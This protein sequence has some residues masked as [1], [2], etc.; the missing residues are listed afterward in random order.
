[1]ATTAITL[2]RHAQQQ[3]RLATITAL[4]RTGT[5]KRTL[6]LLFRSTV[7]VIA[8]SF[9]VAGLILLDSPPAVPVTIS[10]WIGGAA[11]LAL[12]IVADLSAERTAR[13]A[14]E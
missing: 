7:L 2:P 9:F 6:H 8:L 13:P 4:P 5:T 14:A 3:V 12:G 11:T 10:M 1:M